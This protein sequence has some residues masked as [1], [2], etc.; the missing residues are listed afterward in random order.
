MEQSDATVDLAEIQP[1]ALITGTR[2][3]AIAPI[4]GQVVEQGFYVESIRLARYGSIVTVTLPAAGPLDGDVRP[5][6]GADE[7]AAEVY[8]VRM[9]ETLRRDGWDLTEVELPAN[10]EAPF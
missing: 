7:E 9:R 3:I 2:Q 4:A 8:L 1:N 6:I 10:P 5:F